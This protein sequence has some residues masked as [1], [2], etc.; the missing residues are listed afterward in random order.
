MGQTTIHVPDDYGSI[1]EGL[2]AASL[3]DTVLVSPGTYVENIIWP[4]NAQEVKLLSVAGAEETIIDGDEQGRVLM[5]DSL[6]TPLDLNTVI[7]GFSIRNGMGG[8]KVGQS[9]PWLRDLVIE[10]NMLPRGSYQAGAGMLFSY[11]ESKIENCIIRNNANL[12]DDAYGG[13]IMASFSDL[14]LTNCAFIEN[15]MSGKINMVG[16]A[17]FISGALGSKSK[18]KLNACTFLENYTD[19]PPSTL[20]PWET[21]IDLWNVDGLEIVNSVFKDNYSVNEDFANLISVVDSDIKITNCTSVNNDDG[22]VISESSQLEI[23]NSIFYTNGAEEFRFYAGADSSNYSINYSLV[24]GGFPG[25][26]NI[27]VDPEF[28]SDDILVPIRSS[29]CVNAGNN[30]VSPSTDILGNTRPLP[31]GTNVDIG[32]TEIDQDARAALVKFYGDNNENGVK[33][34]DE[35]FYAIGSCE[36]NENQNYLNTRTDGVYV[37]L[38]EGENI[39]SYID[40]P[41]DLWTLSIGPQDFIIDANTDDY[42]ELVTFGLKSVREEKNLDLGI[43]APILVCNRGATMDII[44]KNQGTT[45]ETGTLFLE[46]DERIMEFAAYQSPD[47]EDGNSIGWE[48]ENLGPGEI[49][50]RRVE[51]IVPAV[52]EVTDEL[53]FLAS[54]NTPDDPGWNQE[55]TYEDIVRCAFDPNDKLVYSEREDSLALIRDKLVYTLRFQNVGNY[56]AEDVLVV[57]T[58]DS[59]L[60]MSTFNFL[61]TSHPGVLRITIDDQIVHFNFEQIYLPD[62]SSNFEGSSGYVMFSI[63]ADSTIADYSEIE[64]TAH[65]YFDLNEAIVTNT[66]KSIMV[67][68]FPILDA[69]EENPMLGLKVYPN[70]SQS[71]F[72]FS[73]HLDELIL[74]DIRG[75]ILLRRQEIKQLNLDNYASG[76]YFVKIKK[77]ESLGVMKLVLSK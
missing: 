58:L 55:F 50:K 23:T 17:I 51:I 43:Y 74:F 53:V 71:K 34:A 31:I 38:L 3:G 62:S 65:I 28:V 64:N 13:G 76:L 1:Q 16:A 36:V 21:I 52:N 14:Q 29:V 49:I 66:T 72:Y 57:D 70:P 48:F 47:V 68:E 10:N 9:S 32:A 54:V 24:S 11:S 42:F 6:D 5:I 15:M 73:E 2:D 26:E 59:D 12:N 20:F 60:D 19:L 27:D 63:L 45:I 41:N 46:I 22:I 44:F 40:L 25:V 56:H 37:P 30:L 8:I 4:E 75:N 39:I 67:S 7:D 33:D 61:G 77:G 18:T 35:F 69:T